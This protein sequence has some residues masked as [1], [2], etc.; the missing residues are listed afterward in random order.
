MSE[1]PNT[2]SPV[3]TEKAGSLTDMVKLVYILYFIGYFAGITWIAG[4]IVAYLKRD[5]ADELTATH[6]QYQIRT[7]WIG[8]LYCVVGVILAL[9]LIGWLV[10]LFVV[11]WSLVRS[12]K[13][14][15]AISDGK[16][17]ADPETWLW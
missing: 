11:V 13:G 12:I 6:F 10:F 9:V 17:I 14:F 7:F 1:T 8:L 3:P 15:M 16:P 2:Q 5:E 4:L